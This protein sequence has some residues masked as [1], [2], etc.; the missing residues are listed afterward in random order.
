MNPLTNWLK[1]RAAKVLSKA[2]HDARRQHIR[3]TT[4]AMRKHLKLPV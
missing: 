2:S 1:R 4:M 3:E